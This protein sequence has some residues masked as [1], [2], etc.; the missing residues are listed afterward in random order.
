[1]LQPGDRL[2]IQVIGWLIQ[3]Q[4]IRPWGKR[5]GKRRSPAPPTGKRFQGLAGVQ[6]HLRAYAF[7][8]LLG[9]PAPMCIDMAMQILKPVEARWI[10]IRAGLLTVLLCHPD[11]VG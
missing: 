6:T 8:L 7:D 1:M 4:Q 5:P 2:K 3:Q 9:M 10:K 11:D